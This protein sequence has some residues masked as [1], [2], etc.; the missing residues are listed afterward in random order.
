MSLARVQGRS[1]SPTVVPLETLDVARDL[2]KGVPAQAAMA[3]ER[4]DADTPAASVTAPSSAV[5]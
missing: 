5:N 4:T 1:W 3:T 2:V